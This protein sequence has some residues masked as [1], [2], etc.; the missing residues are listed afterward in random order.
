MGL[1][2]VI[3]IATSEMSKATYDS[4]NDGRIDI[5]QNEIINL[6]PINGNG[7]A[8]TTGMKG[9]FTVPYNCII[10]GAYIQVDT[11]STTTIDLWKCTYAQFDAGGTHPVDGDSITSADQLKSIAST[12]GYNT[13]LT[14]WTTTL[15]R[16][17]I[18]AINV[19]ANNNAT[20][21]FIS[22]SVQRTNSL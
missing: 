21:I 3:P 9:Y 4:D 22:L 13:S 18:L 7:F 16:G 12:K 19:D 1:S 14:G 2:L 15:T 5:V 8:V 11:S 17:D 10:T 20:K 6:W